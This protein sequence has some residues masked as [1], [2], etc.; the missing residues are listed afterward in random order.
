MRIVAVLNHKGGVGKTTFTGSAAQALA[1]C[2]FRVCVIDNDS[3]HNL[4]TMLDAGVQVPSVRDVYGSDESGAPGVMLRAV[5]KTGIENLHIITGDKRLCAADVPDTGHLG[6]VMRRCRLERFY[7]MILIDNAPGLDRLQG[8]AIEAA[9]EIF[10]PVE[11]RQFAVDGLVEM[12]R[13]IR[14][15]YPGGKGIT[16]I[17]PNF[18]RNTRRQRTFV[19]ALRRMFPGKVTETA[20]PQDSVFD[21]VITERKILFLHRLYSNGAAHYL[22]IVHELFDLDEENVWEQVMQKRKERIRFEARVRFENRAR[23][24]AQKGS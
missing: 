10:V 13:T 20:L 14:E 3:Q 16:R 17:I 21:E 22:K 12:D 18:F 1:L 24:I 19:A 4:S 8:S 11:L 9:D 23:G 2:G 15:R 7:D 5:R 6:K